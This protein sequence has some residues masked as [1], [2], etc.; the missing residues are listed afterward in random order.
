MRK[1]LTALFIATAMLPSVVSADTIF[2]VYAGGQ[3]WRTDA[4]GSFATSRNLRESDFDSEQQTSAYVAIEHPI[5]LIPNLKI[6]QNQLEVSGS[7]T[8]AREF[9]FAN[10]SWAAGS[11]VRT[12]V[13]LSH[14]DF[15]LYYE[16]LDNDLVSLDLGATAK[17]IDG[18]LAVSDASQT[19]RLATDGWVPTLYAHGRVGIPATDVTIYALANA[20]SIGDSSIRDIE[21]GIEYR[22][23][24]NIALDVNLQIGYRDITIELDNL[25]GIYSD[26]SFKGPYL[27]LEIHF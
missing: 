21:A 22:L 20:I 10:A 8:L 6:R 7:T 14:T 24:E 3:Y 13:D 12:M 23:L 5:P 16:L 27:G 9:N 19:A 26:M 18:Q 25:D 15:T 17:R 2:G 1:T 4:N 11:A